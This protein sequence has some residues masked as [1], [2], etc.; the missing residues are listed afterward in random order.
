MPYITPCQKDRLD[1]F[2]DKL[3]DRIDLGLTPGELT[4]VLY[5]ICKK[6]VLMSK[7]YGRMALVEGILNCVG[8]E[9][10]RRIVAPYEDKKIKEN[11][12]V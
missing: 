8:K 1:P 4:Y 2:L 12:D 10:Y 3:L 9:L 7:H 11:G 5:K 6:W